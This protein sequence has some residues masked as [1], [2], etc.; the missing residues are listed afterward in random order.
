MRR[1]GTTGIERPNILVCLSDQLRAFEIGCYG[2]EV[3]RT[4][5]T[6]RLATEGV[7]FETAVT[8]FP[9]CMAAR[10]IL[11]SGL[12]NRSCTGGVA[13]VSF[14]DD[15]TGI[16]F[17]PEYPVGGRP[18]L[19]CRTLPE[20]LRDLGYR[21][22]A[23]GKWH[24]H[25]WPHEI[26]FDEYLIPRV[27][28][29]H[30]GQSYTENGGAE[31]VPGTYSVDFEAERVAQFLGGQRDTKDPFFLYY[32]ISVPHCPLAD[33]PDR[34]RDM[35]EAEKMP[36]RDNVDP[37][38]PIRDQAHWFKVYR[39]DYRYY[40]LRLP[41]TEVLP[42]PYTIRHVLAEYYGM[43]TWMDDA[44][45]RLLKALEDNGLAENTIVV[46]GSDH[47][48]NLGS[49]GF[50]QKGGVNEE[51]IRVPFI[52]RAPFLRMEPSVIRTHVASLVDIAPTILSMIDA[53]IPKH[54]QGRNLAPLCRGCDQDVP[55][56]AIIETV[57]G[58]AI[59]SSGHLYALPFESRDSH[60]LAAKP[61]HFFDL[62]LDPYQQQNRAGDC[63]QDCV[64]SGLAEQ[65]REWDS[66][67]HWMEGR[68]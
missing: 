1:R 45:G 15:E 21:S 47:G 62:R 2:N 60:A 29:C 40:R 7:R 8:N 49:H 34:Y 31:F 39:Y 59:R 55:T 67:T 14:R 5:N 26:G 6:D 20:V 58:A 36:L 25:T 46:F 30:T 35:Y 38:R 66:R 52:V 64:A 42:E 43:V 10:S 63:E 33:C 12:Y 41:Y 27:S 54:F 51:S 50:V 17:M 19:P 48:D 56:H 68:R 23:I 53:P 32:N 37:D 61:S 3:V 28:H 11:L 9:V 13:N 44:L 24:I 57:R 65:L 18:H 16:S 4:P 22:A